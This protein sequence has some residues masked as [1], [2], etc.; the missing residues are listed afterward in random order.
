MRDPG[1]PGSL[2]LAGT[3]KNATKGVALAEAPPHTFAGVV[4][5]GSC[6]VIPSD[7]TAPPRQRPGLEPEVAGGRNPLLPSRE[8]EDPWLLLDAPGTA[9]AG[10]SAKDFV[11][12]IASARVTR[13]RRKPRRRGGLEEAAPAGA[14][15]PGRGAPEG[16]CQD[17]GA[18]RAQGPAADRDPRQGSGE[19]GPRARPGSGGYVGFDRKMGS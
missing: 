6:A 14:R 4:S 15:H 2:I 7:Q 19:G 16:R 11:K 18:R 10:G 8:I 17:R 13:R 12:T 9:C 1:L 3:K 5:N